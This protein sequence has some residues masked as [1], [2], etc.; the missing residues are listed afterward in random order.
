MFRPTHD[1]HQAKQQ[2]N[3]SQNVAMQPP[4]VGG[5]LLLK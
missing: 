5:I 3:V 1:A 2:N 4:L